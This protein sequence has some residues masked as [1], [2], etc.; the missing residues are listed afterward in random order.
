[1]IAVIALYDS[2][3]VHMASIM[4][5]CL[6]NCLGDNRREWPSQTVDTTRL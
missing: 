5:T 1:M 6:P 2:S 4:Y 3:D